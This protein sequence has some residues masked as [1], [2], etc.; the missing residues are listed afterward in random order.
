[1]ITDNAKAVPC[2]VVLIAD[3]NLR[4][5]TYRKMV[6][7]DIKLIPTLTRPFFCL[8]VIDLG[9]LIEGGDNTAPEDFQQV[10]EIVKSIYHSF[11]VSVNGTHAAVAVYAGTTKIIF[12][13]VKF[14]DYTNMDDTVDGTP[15]HAGLSNAK[16]GNALREV[17]MKIFDRTARKG[18]P[19]VLIT[20]M[21]GRSDDAIE[22]PANAL[23]KS[24]V[25][26]FALGLSSKYSP[27]DLNQVAGVPPS[28]YILI[29]ETLNDPQAIAQAIVGKVKKG[30]TQKGCC[31]R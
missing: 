26:M 31:I 6:Q 22:P 11:P 21:T 15:Y 29:S 7:D 13:L 4:R 24:C 20:V 10:K 9:I 1:M 18:V 8:D 16:A 3:P 17:K 19:H 30:K 5:C 28:E 14:F 27:V 12:N 23:K 2:S 25:L